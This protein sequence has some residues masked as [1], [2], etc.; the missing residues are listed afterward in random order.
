M[1]YISFLMS[2]LLIYTQVTMSLII[3]TKFI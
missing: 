2:G 1:T 3:L